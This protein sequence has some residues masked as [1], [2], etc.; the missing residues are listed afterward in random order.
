MAK[1]V[2]VLRGPVHSSEIP[3]WDIEEDGFGL[4]YGE[5]YVLWAT[6]LDERGCLDEEQLIFEDFTEAAAVVDHFC[7]Q[8]VPLEWDDT[9]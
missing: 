2:N 8:I 6:V 3:D 7:Q 9:F 5:G 1:I 4:P